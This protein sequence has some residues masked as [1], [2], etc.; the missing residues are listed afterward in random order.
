MFDVVWVFCI[1]DYVLDDVEDDCV[2]DV[3]VDYL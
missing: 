1:C 3:F 2:D